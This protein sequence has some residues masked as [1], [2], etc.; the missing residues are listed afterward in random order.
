[1]TFNEKI[2]KYMKDNNIP[3]LKKFAYLANI[4]YTTLHDF[5][6]KKVQIIQDYLQ[7]ENYQVL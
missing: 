7:L 4:P 5:Y 1:M 3:N 2:D 6:E